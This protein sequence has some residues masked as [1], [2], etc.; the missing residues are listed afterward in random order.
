M[1]SFNLI[2]GTSPLAA[3]T[4]FAGSLMGI[5]SLILIASGTLKLNQISGDDVLAIEWRNRFR[6][7]TQIPGVALFVFSAIFLA[8][9]FYFQD[10]FYKHQARTVKEDKPTVYIEGEIIGKNG[11][12]EISITE[13]IK[14]VVSPHPTTALI[15][16]INKFQAS[17]DPDSGKYIV[18]F[19]VDGYEP[20]SKVIQIGEK[21]KQEIGRVILIKL[22]SVDGSPTKI[23]PLPTDFGEMPAPNPDVNTGSYGSAVAPMGVAEPADR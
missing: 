10:Q 3:V 14:I 5:G 4:V 15:P 2:D 20:T 11:D 13:P 18:S 21:E 1:A 8:A 19:L 6:L 16:E 12:D 23:D 9:G 22:P 17:I 7:N